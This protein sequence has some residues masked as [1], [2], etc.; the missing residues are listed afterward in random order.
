MK[1]IENRRKADTAKPTSGFVSLNKTTVYIS[2]PAGKAMG[3]S[4]KKRVVFTKKYNSPVIGILDSDNTKYT[5]FTPN[6][7]AG[8]AATLANPKDLR[9]SCK[10]G[11]YFIARSE[12][13]D[14]VTWHYLKRYA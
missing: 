1:V 7:N 6:M 5:G 3:L 9:A 8:S 12:N 14:G 4:R 13:K 11:R 2:D 10:L